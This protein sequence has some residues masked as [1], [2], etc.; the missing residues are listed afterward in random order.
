MMNYIISWYTLLLYISL[1]YTEDN[2][3]NPSVIFLYS[4]MDGVTCQS[5]SSCII[6][7]SMLARLDYLRGLAGIIR[8]EKAHLR[9][10]RFTAVLIFL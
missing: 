7:M 3:A 8:R 5:V 2:W 4:G 6:N 10:P 1:R 9:E